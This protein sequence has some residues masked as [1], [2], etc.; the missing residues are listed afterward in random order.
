MGA[1]KKCRSNQCLRSEEVC[2]E[3]EIRPFCA[4][5]SEY[6]SSLSCLARDQMLRFPYE[7][8]VQGAHPGGRQHSGVNSLPLLS[9]PRLSM[10]S[11]PVIVKSRRE[12]YTAGDPLFFNRRNQTVV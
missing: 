2:S 1:N 7:F 6:L 9:S 12:I 3:H 5:L 4:D 8:T 10:S 11:L